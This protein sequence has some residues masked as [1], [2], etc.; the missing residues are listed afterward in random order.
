MKMSKFAVCFDLDT[1]Q[2]DDDGL[3]KGQ[4]TTVYAQA[5]E[6]FVKCGLRK[7]EQHSMYSTEDTDD[8]FN[9]ILKV[10]TMLKSH[11]RSFCRY[12]SRFDVVQIQDSTDMVEFLK[13]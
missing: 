8:A 7:H 2:M 6:V 1:K 11:A 10:P 5:K 3:T 13:N 9:C 4:I 12:L